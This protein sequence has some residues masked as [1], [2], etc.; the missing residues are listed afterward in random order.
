V[1]EFSKLQ[2][3]EA[4]HV[5]VHQESH[6]LL[7]ALELPPTASNLLAIGWTFARGEF[8]GLRVDVPVRMASASA[9]VAL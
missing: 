9:C 8:D 6:N 2:I 1:L 7:D 4:R 3:E 5:I